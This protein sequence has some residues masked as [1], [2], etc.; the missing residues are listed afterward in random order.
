MDVFHFAEFGKL[1]NMHQTID[2]YS[3]FQWSTASSSEKADSIIADLSE[4][5]TIM[6]IP[7]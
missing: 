3:E 4:V 1:K 5:T 2:T 6:G 7:V